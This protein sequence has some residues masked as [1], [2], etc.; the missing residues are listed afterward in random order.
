VRPGFTEP[1]PSPEAVNT[2]LADRAGAEAW[3]IE[4]LLEP[5]SGA[6]LTAAGAGT[7]FASWARDWRVPGRCPYVTEKEANG[8]TI[9][10]RYVELRRAYLD[11]YLLPEFGH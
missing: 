6:P 8:F 4:R 7:T 10:P 2:H 5:A 3:A 9:S 1:H 11:N